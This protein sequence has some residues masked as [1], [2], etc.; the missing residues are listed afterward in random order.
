MSGASQSDQLIDSALWLDVSG[1]RAGAIELL[2]RVLRDDPGNARAEVGLQKYGAAVPP[3][4][5]PSPPPCEKR[6]LS[7]GEPISQ[8]SYQKTFPMATTPAQNAGFT[9]DR[10]IEAHLPFKGG[11]RDTVVYIP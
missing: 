6:N 9:R 8:R 3:G 5:N 11:M 4:L 2:K 7:V 1:D 10:I